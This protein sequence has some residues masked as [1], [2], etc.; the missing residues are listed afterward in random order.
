MLPNRPELTAEEKHAIKSLFAENS[1]YSNATKEI[2]K[3]CI[4]DSDELFNVLTPFK[5]K[6][7]ANGEWEYLRSAFDIQV[8]MELERDGKNF[9]VD[10]ELTSSEKLVIEVL[11]TYYKKIRDAIR[12]DKHA[13]TAFIH[14]SKKRF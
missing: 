12:E 9:I 14:L 3:G 10:Q 4:F 11:S 1:N 13:D 7:P 5:Y 6:T 2:V 8:G